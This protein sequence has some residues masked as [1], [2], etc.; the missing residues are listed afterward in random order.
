MDDLDHLVH[1]PRPCTRKLT[2]PPVS[3]E[4]SAI[5]IQHGCS[6]EGNSLTLPEG[7]TQAEILPRV[8]AARY[9][10]KFP[11]G[12]NIVEHLERS[13]ISALYL[14]ASDLPNQ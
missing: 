3:N 11:D 7:T 10:L 8:N 2:I 12:Y 9:R 1:Y 4:V 13:G 14:P 5:L 6:L